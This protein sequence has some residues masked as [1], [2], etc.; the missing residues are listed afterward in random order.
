MGGSV[1]VESK[2]GEGTCFVV[3]LQ[4]KCPPPSSLQEIKVLVDA[5]EKL[6]VFD[7]SQVEIPANLLSPEVKVASGAKFRI[8]LVNDEPFQL[9]AYKL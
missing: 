8:L 5:S 9:Y 7:K 3:K 4:A 6:I 2:L 1:S